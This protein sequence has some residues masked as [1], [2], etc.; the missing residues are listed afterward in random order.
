MTAAPVPFG[1]RTG[2]DGLR[3]MS[4]VRVDPGQFRHLVQGQIDGV[5]A[6][7]IHPADIREAGYFFPGLP[8]GQ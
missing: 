8:Q 4:E 5:P 6:H 7:L 3:C 2:I 1:G